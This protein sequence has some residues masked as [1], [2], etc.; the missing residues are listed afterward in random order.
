RL[1]APTAHNRDLTAE[2]TPWLLRFRA[3]AAE[4]LAMLDGEGVLADRGATEPPQVFGDVL[5][6]FVRA[7]TGPE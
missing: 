6:M 3:G 1:L 2:L 5:D 4:I 7:R